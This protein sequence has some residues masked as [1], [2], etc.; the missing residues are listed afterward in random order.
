MNSYFARHE[1]DKKGEG[2]GVD[3]AGYIAWLLWG[4]DAGWRWA[5]SILE[6]KVKTMTQTHSYAAITKMDKN[7]D[8]TLT[9]YGK[10][11]DDS[12]DSDQQICD[13]TWLKRAMPDWM[14]SGGNVREQHSNIAAGV[15]TDYEVKE[16]G[17]YITALV[18]DPVSVKKVE[19]GVLK[20]FSIGINRPRVI[21]DEKAVGGRIVDGQI[22]EISLVDRPANPN[23]K[24]MLAKAAENGELMAVTQMPT[25]KEVF[26]KSPQVLPDLVEADDVV[27]DAPV[28]DVVSDVIVEDVPVEDAPVEE[29][30]ARADV[31]KFDQKL[32]DNAVFALAEL[33]KYE[34]NEIVTEGD[35]ETG[36]IKC[37]LKAM[38]HLQ[39]FHKREADKGEA[40]PLPSDDRVDE[41]DDMVLELAASPDDEMC[42]KCGKSMKMCKCDKSDDMPD[43]TDEVEKSISFNDAQIE[44]VVEKAVASAK[45][46]VTEELEQLRTALKAVEAE[47]VQITGELES[48]KKAAVAGGPKR[49]AT[50]AIDVDIPELLQKATEYRVKASSTNDRDLARGYVE[51]AEDLETK[52][53]RKDV[54]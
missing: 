19:K 31:V 22:V 4:G 25:P 42:D 35:D 3:S 23:A 40:A 29:K 34:T 47:K 24:L 20:G 8:G 13:D 30:S 45:A 37:L 39:K 7:E 14:L 52:A 17:H 43:E 54:K 2:W 38:K 36:D 15:A 11:T 28:E 12:I 49:S 26:G 9:V 33:I 16:D 50:K 10:A 27:E 21:R 1:V 41:D 44:A 51:L 48:A 32:Y 46:S 6:N 18:V 5:K 53:S